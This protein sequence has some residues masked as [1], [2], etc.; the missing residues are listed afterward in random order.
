MRTRI[1][2]SA[3]LWLALGLVS[4]WTG[5]AEL[6]GPGHH[7]CQDCEQGPMVESIEYQN[8][9]SHRCKM[10]DD[11]KVTKKWVYECKEVPFCLH[12][13]PRVGQCDCCPECQACPRYKR[14]LI[15]KEIVVCEEPITK[16]VP[17]ECVE[18]VAVKVCRPA[19]PCNNACPAQAPCNNAYYQGGAAAPVVAPVVPDP[20]IPTPPAPAAK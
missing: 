5:A 18:T 12:R 15:K 2:V 4:T 1:T 9:V 11:K 17:E 10:V 20:S 14:V 19:Q 3:L 6:L 13:V 16:C 8:V 7:R